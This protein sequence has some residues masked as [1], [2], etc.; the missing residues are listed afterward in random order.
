MIADRALVNEHFERLLE[1]QDAQAEAELDRM[2]Q[3]DPGLHAELSA[4]LDADRKAEQL[5]GLD[6][7]VPASL[8]L[9][10]GSTFGPYELQELLGSGGGGRVYRARRSDGR[11]EH[12]VAIK[13]LALAASED[14]RRRFRGEMQIL[15]RLNHPNIV[16]LLDGGDTSDGVYYLV[17]QW[18]DGRSLTEAAQSLKLAERLGLLLQLCGAVEYA[19]RRLIVH[20]DLKPSNVLVDSEGQIKL[21]DFGISKDLDAG[22]TQTQAVM[23]PRYAAPEQILGEPVTTATDVFALGMLLFELLTDSLP[24]IPTAESLG[25]L[26]DYARHFT[27]PPPSRMTD[28]TIAA[29]L[30]AIVLKCLERDPDRRYATVAELANDLQRFL[31]G[32]PISA[33]VLNPLQRA[34]RWA[35][36]NRGLVTTLLAAVLLGSAAVTLHLRQLAQERDQAEAALAFVIGLFGKLNPFDSGDEE[37]LEIPVADVYR[38]GLE[39]LE[40]AVMLSPGSKSDLAMAFGAGL[41]DAGRYPRALEAVQSAKALLA[42]SPRGEQS[43]R[44]ARVLMLEARAQSFMG[45]DEEAVAALAAA[46]EEPVIKAGDNMQAGRYWYQLGNET[47]WGGD[48]ATSRSHLQKAVTVMQ[49]HAVTEA[50]K[51]LLYQAMSDLAWGL[52]DTGDSEPALEYISQAVEGAEALGVSEV[53]LAL[54]YAKRA[55]IRERSLYVGA[56]DEDH[57]RATTLVENVLGPTHRETLAITG[58]YALSLIRQHRYAESV[59]IFRSLIETTESVENYDP[60]ELAARYQ[61][62]AAAQ[63]GLG[64]YASAETSAKRA[65]ALYHDALGPD[66]YRNAF[67]LMTFAE[68]ALLQ[69]EPERAFE[70]ADAAVSLLHVLPPEHNLVLTASAFR[71]AASADECRPAS[72]M[73]KDQLMQVVEFLGEARRSTPLVEALLTWPD[74]TR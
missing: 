34:G 25:E 67:P 19:H 72:G 3:T 44:R 73:S 28:R 27:C 47:Y 5:L 20:R 7:A 57:L 60:I 2:A 40:S 74:C 15:A 50:E 24:P 41:I 42:Q 12:T 11:F 29:D 66:H 68:L 55:S 26:V 36:R 59:P 64:D 13:F 62:L 56:G 6:T 39:E 69:D 71:L 53:R 58:N 10:T 38:L 45:N 30:D 48:L 49:A 52:A 51:L 33:R 46:A 23:T 16:S 18:V 43:V 22:N 37:A 61:N 35:R 1:M 4:L 8:E 14:A 9:M 21:L 32:R 63:K 17:M 31:E 54:L 70:P 65:H